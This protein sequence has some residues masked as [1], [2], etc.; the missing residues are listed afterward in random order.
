LGLLTCKNRLPYNLYC[1]GGDVTHCSLTHSLTAMR[2]RLDCLVR[3]HNCQL[4]NHLVNC[5]FLQ[6]ALNQLHYGKTT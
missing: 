1:V 2:Q 5:M 6:P 3:D 4:C